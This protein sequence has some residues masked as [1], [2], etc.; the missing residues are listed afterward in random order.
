MAKFLCNGML[1]SSPQENL[2]EFVLFKGPGK[3]ERWDVKA[4]ALD[5]AVFPWTRIRGEKAWTFKWK[6]KWESRK[7]MA[8]KYTI[9][10]LYGSVSHSLAV[11]LLTYCPPAYLVAELEQKGF[12][13]SAH[14]RYLRGL[15]WQVSICCVSCSTLCLNTLFILNL[16]IFQGFIPHCLKK[17]GTSRRKI[18]SIQILPFSKGN[19][20]F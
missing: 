15:R 7:E 18:Q 3:R 2:L 19:S 5:L 8:Y 10:K 14:S 11:A 1:D 17:Y 4:T 16:F 12:T 9:D 13:V 6:L 20:N